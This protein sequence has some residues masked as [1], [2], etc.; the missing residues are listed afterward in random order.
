M[1]V[2]INSKVSERRGLPAIWLE[3]KKL[4]VAFSPN[5]QY[6]KVFDVAQS[7]LRLVKAANDGD[8]NVS[9]RN[10]RKGIEGE[11]QPLIEL[12]DED[13]LKLFWVG[14][15]LRIVVHDNGVDVTIQSGELQKRER[16]K[17]M[18]SK[19]SNP[20]GEKLVCGSQYTGAG[21]LDRAVHDGLKMAGFDS[22]LKVAVESE[23]A[24]VETLLRNQSELF[25][26]D[27]IVINSLVGDVEFRGSC[28]LD[29]LVAGIP[30]TAASRAGRS[31]KKLVQAEDD[32]S[33]GDC[34]FHTLNFI[35]QTQPWLV[36]LENVVDYL[37]SASFSVIKNVMRGWGYSVSFQTLNGNEMGALENRDRLSAVFITELDFVDSTFDYSFV[38]PIRTKEASLADVM[39]E[40]PAD[41]PEYK[42]YSYLAEKE[43]RDAL[44][45]NN[46]KRYIYDGSEESITT[47]RRLY[48][49]GGSCDQFARSPFDADLYRLFLP[50]EHAAFKGINFD[51][52]SGAS[53]TLQHEMLGQSVIFPA[54]VALALGVGKFLS[55]EIKPEMPM[56][57]AA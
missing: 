13:L 2:I 34:F 40:L 11:P 23:S 52:V 9:V 20:A 54:F 17:R 53:K 46:F 47:I 43:K 32:E 1:I 29:V 16:A 26:D 19:L 25:Q 49:K 14:C 6:K 8:G 48:H 37:Q 27:S 57:I 42:S 45:G 44:K 24:Y 39:V 18:L 51:F 55:T 31:K 21:I 4:A 3:G 12:R 28:K 36:I 56:P 10:P 22:Y 50:V 7:R 30:C 5:D 38:T 33:A 35:N 15:K 41:S